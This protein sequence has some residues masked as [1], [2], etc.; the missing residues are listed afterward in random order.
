MVV[1]L[2]ANRLGTPYVVCPAGALPIFGRSRFIK[3][4]YNKLWGKSIIRKANYCIAVTEKEI[5]DFET[6]GVG[7][8]K[9]QVIPNG[10]DVEAVPKPNPE[11]WKQLGLPDRPFILFLGRLNEIKGPDLLL[12]AY[13]DCSIGFDLVYVGPDGGMLEKLKMY[14]EKAGMVNN[15]HFVGPLYGDDK[16]QAY[17]AAQALVVPSRHEAMS[18]VAVESGITGTAVMLSDQCGFDEVQDVGGGIV[19][20]A[21][22]EGL[23]KGLLHLERNRRNLPVMGECLRE[24]I[25]ENFAWGKLVKRYDTLYESMLSLRA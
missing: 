25:L 18:I 3:L 22:V 8:K 4:L 20:T 5:A 21:S 24:H 14:R 6:Y 9:I 11:I 10:V 2:L 13:A 23:R 19:V 15:V 12:E 17:Y 16:Y 1:Y 7:R